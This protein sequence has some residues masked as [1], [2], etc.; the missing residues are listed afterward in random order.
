MLYLEEPAGSQPDTSC[1]TAGWHRTW[2]LYWCLLSA[3][4]LSE[5]EIWDWHCRKNEMAKKKEDSF[6]L[7][8]ETSFLLFQQHRFELFLPEV[9][10]SS[11]IDLLSQYISNGG[12]CHNISMQKSQTQSQ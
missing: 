6:K 4:Y 8:I 1:Q 2:S 3:S 10:K 11:G 7:Q 12:I 9:V 5:W